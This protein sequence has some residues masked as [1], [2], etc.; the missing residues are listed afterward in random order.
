MMAMAMAMLM[1]M[2]RVMV[3]NLLLKLNACHF[4]CFHIALNKIYI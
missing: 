2:V 1:V 3:T 4:D